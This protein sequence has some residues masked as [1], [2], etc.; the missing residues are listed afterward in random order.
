RGRADEE[1]R[2]VG[3]PLTLFASPAPALRS[4]DGQLTTAGRNLEARRLFEKAVEFDS[5][6]AAGHAYLALTIYVEWTSNRAPG[7]LDRALSS[8]RHALALDEN[9]RLCHRILGGIL[10]SCA[11]LIV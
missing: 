10:N 2:L 6:Y 11:T 1:G 4:P 7:E 8:A 3:P 5:Q 9:D